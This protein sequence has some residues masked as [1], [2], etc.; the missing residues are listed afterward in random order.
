MDTSK[1]VV[2]QRVWMRSG[3]LLREATVIEVTEEYIAAKPVSFEQNE[4]PWM[5]HFQKDGKQFSVQDLVARTGSG[6][7]DWKDLWN[8]GAYELFSGEWGRPDPF[9]L[10]G[11]GRNPWELNCGD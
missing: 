1:L 11:D 6:D 4:R 3:S 10:S 9:P 2:G 5:I 8:L 7:I